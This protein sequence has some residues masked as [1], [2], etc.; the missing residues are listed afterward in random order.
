G[1]NLTTSQTCHLNSTSKVVPTTGP[2]GL[3]LAND[4]ALG[5]Y[6]GPTQTIALGPGSAAIDFV[7]SSFCA[8]LKDAGGNPLTT[9]QRGV[10]RPQGNGCD[11][12]AYEA[13]SLS[14][15][16]SPASPNG[17]PPWYKQTPTVT[18]G[19]GGLDVG[20]TASCTQLSGLTIT[21][22]QPDQSGSAQVLPGDGQYS[23]DC[24]VAQG[25]IALGFSYSGA[26]LPLTL[27]ID[28]TPPTIDLQTPAAT[29]YTLQAKVE[30]DYSCSDPKAPDGAVGSGITA[31]NC[32]GS[33]PSGQPVDT[34]T[35]GQ[36]KFTVSAS[37]NAGN[38]T[39]KSVTYTVAYATPS[40][41]GSTTTVQRGYYALI[42]FAPEDV[43]GHDY[44]SRN[45]KVTTV[46]LDGDGQTIPFVHQF[47]FAQLNGQPGYQLEINTR[48]LAPGSWTLEVTI[49]NAATLYPISFTVE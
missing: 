22:S 26:S 40:L 48:S 7:P 2:G 5:S 45:L 27:D 21:A 18:L 3:N 8:T 38:T 23:I 1:Y 25:Q 49:G 36:H 29:T 33:V 24:G 10:T 31:A 11:A 42:R 43:N 17:N 19:T 37:D 30:A 32:K 6:G 20:Q 9:D 39:T 41:P 44:A 16:V 34:G 46:E 15:N 47:Q 28:T 12:G 14:L 13:P 35:P 4:G